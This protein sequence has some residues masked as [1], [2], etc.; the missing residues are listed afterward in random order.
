MPY[1]ERKW[2]LFVDGENFTIQGQKKAS[3]LNLSLAEDGPYFKRDSFLWMPNAR[4]LRRPQSASAEVEVLEDPGLRAY[5]YTSVVGSEETVKAIE[6]SVWRIGFTPKV[7]K[8]PSGGKSKGV[9]I[10]LTTDM[11]THA[12]QNH[13][14]VAVLLAGDAD[15]KPLVGRVKSLGKLVWVWYFGDKED[16]LGLE[17]KL[18][19]DLFIPLDNQFV[20]EWPVMKDLGA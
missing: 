1:T 19:A 10:S 4:P 7:F 8:K 6:E 3:R 5:Y 12:F 17:L 15:Y 13:F 9:D 16:G 20:R 18:A 2:M 14:E 11:L